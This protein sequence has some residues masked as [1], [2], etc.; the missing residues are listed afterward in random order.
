MRLPK[1]EPSINLGK[2]NDVLKIERP[3][4]F[5]LLSVIVAA[6]Q[7]AKIHSGMIWHIK[8]IKVFFIEIKNDDVLLRSVKFLYHGRPFE[9]SS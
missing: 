4:T 9:V 8:K 1:L 5:N 2:K 3:F 6:S 7:N